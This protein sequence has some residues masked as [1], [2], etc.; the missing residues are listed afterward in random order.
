MIES[1]RG[2]YSMNKD[3]LGLIKLTEDKFYKWFDT[4]QTH[5]E[6]RRVDVFCHKGPKSLYAVLEEFA[7]VWDHLTLTE[8]YNLRNT[9]KGHKE[10]LLLNKQIKLCRECWSRKPKAIKHDLRTTPKKDRK[11]SSKPT[12]RTYEFE[13]VGGLESGFG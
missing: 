4:F 10:V 3:I 7:K 8:W 11:N 2:L 6:L 12:H 9:M 13:G 1:T 5:E